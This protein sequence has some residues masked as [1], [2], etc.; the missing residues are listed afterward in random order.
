MVLITRNG[1]RT[2]REQLDAVAAQEWDQSWELLVID[3]ASDDDTPNILAEFQRR[4]PAVRLVNAND[5]LGAGYARNVGIRAALGRYIAFVDDDDRVGQGWLSAIGTAVIE[6]EYVG[7]RLEVD[8][9]NEPGVRS[10]R[11]P[12]QQGAVDRFCGVGVCAAPLMAVSREWLLAV[13]GCDEEIWPEDTD[14]ALRLYSKYLREPFFCSDAIY[15]YRLRCQPLEIYRQSFRY[16]LVRPLLLK[17]W[18]HVLK[19]P[20]RRGRVAWA[21]WSRLVL[22]APRAL[23]SRDRRLRWLRRVGTRVGHLV[24]TVKHRSWWP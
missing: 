11:S 6:H 9:L 24:G 14:L 5:N 4:N 23:S 19:P 18:R 17:R 16:G 13:G 22:S 8:E 12:A 7:A 10:S 2:V 15:H 3:N 20:A 21:E 1:Q